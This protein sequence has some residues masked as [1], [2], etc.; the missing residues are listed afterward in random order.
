M[1]TDHAIRNTCRSGSRWEHARAIEAHVDAQE[2]GGR[3]VD[4]VERR[5]AR[6]KCSNGKHS[7]VQRLLLLLH[8]GEPSFKPDAP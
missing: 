4:D 7:D 2:D 6:I 1:R 5:G 3:G 8:P